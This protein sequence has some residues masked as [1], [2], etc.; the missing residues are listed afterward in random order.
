MSDR[1]WDDQFRAFLRRTGEDLKKIG[2]ELRSEAQRLLDKAQDP[3]TQEKM[4]AK[5]REVG[6]WAKQT[7]ADVAE[8]VEKGAQK[9]EDAVRNVGQKV[10][11]EVRGPAPSAPKSS[12]PE[13]APRAAAAT[14]KKAAPVEKTVGPKKRPSGGA[15]K[16]KAPRATPAKK[17]IGRKPKS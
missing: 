6:A 8:L 14:A 12:A 1:S 7:V 4:R 3:K 16:K 2:A 5:A 11:T 9:A 15:P 17:T 10:T 13:A